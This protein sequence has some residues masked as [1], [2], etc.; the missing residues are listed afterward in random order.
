MLTISDIP[1]VN[2][3]VQLCLMWFTFPACICSLQFDFLGVI[4]IDVG[5]CALEMLVSRGQTL[6]VDVTATTIK[7]LTG[8]IV[9]A[10][11]Q[12]LGMKPWHVCAQYLN[13]WY[14]N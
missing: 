12:S 10:S 1:G 8:V 4:S 13:A 6:F 11:M 14:M 7:R 3:G 2:R 5:A 9:F